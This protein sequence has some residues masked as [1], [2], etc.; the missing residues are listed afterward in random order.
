MDTKAKFYELT[1]ALFEMVQK[2]DEGTKSWALALKLGEELGEF[3]EAVLKDYDYLKHK[4]VG[5]GVWGEVADIINVLIGFLALHYPEM[6]AT[7]LTE[8]L[9]ESVALKGDKYAHVIG[10]DKIRL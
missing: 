6:T 2:H 5:E 3:Q 1:E 8:K 10:A 9:Y 7:Q 4:P